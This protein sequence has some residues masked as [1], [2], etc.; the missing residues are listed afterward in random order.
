MASPAPFQLRSVD[1]TKLYSSIVD[2]IVDAIRGGAYA[3]GTALPAERILAQQLA[4]SRSSVREAIRVLEHAGVVDVRIG[5][6]TYVTEASSLKAATLRAHT[7]LLGESSPIDV[8]VARRAIEPVCAREAAINARDRDLEALR[9]ALDEQEALTQQHRNPRPADMRFHVAVAS[10]TCNPV[11][12]LIVQRLAD[13]MQEGYQELQ[14]QTEQR[15]GVWDRYLEQHGRVFAAIKSRDPEAAASAMIWH[16]DA[17][18]A[19][20]MSGVG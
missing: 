4:V 17:V 3:P 16:L 6:G 9:Q 19:E 5:S 15:P 18:A 2:Q 10:A 11:L 13:M 7:A 12:A 20:L 1:R 14:H 8:M